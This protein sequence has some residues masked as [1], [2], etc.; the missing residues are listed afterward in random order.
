[1]ASKI[2][3]WKTAEDFFLVFSINDILTLRNNFR[4]QGNLI[5]KN[6]CDSREFF[7]LCLNLEEIILG[8]EAGFLKIKA[9]DVFFSP[10]LG[11]FFLRYFRRKRLSKK[12]LNFLGSKQKKK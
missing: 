2:I 6:F 7:Y 3:V 10:F 1:M 11:K 8:I 4:I 12:K 9:F 5:K